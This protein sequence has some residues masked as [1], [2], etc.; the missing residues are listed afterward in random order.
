MIAYLAKSN[1]IFEPNGV[2]SLWQTLKTPQTILLK[3]M[4]CTQ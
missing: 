3:I 1:F 2:P 4:N